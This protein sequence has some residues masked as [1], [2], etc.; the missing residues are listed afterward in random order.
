MRATFMVA[1]KQKGEAG[2]E[3]EE[4]EGADCY[5]CDCATRESGRGGVGHD[6]VLEREELGADYAYGGVVGCA[7]GDEGQDGSGV[8]GCVACYGGRVGDIAPIRC[9]CQRWNG[10]ER[11]RKGE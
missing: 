11:E 8:A 4:C 7:W 5:A 6:G 1:E 3:R 10:E 2:Q 9:C